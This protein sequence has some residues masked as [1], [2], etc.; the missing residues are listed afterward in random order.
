MSTPIFPQVDPVT[1]AL[2][3]PTEARYVRSNTRGAVSGVAGLNGSGQVIDST[4]TVVTNQTKSGLGLA[5]ARIDVFWDAVTGWP[6][7]PATTGG[8]DWRGGPTIPPPTG[9]TSGGGGMVIGKPPGDLWHA[10]Q[11]G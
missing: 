4:G 10:E 11:V 2:P 1:G 7:R 6:A 9:S 3:A 5:T 8:V